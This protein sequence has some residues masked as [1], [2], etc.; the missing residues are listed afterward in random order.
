MQGSVALENLPG[1]GP[2]TQLQHIAVGRLFVDEVEPRQIEVSL[3][4]RR[5]SVVHALR[6]QIHPIGDIHLQLQKVDA[7]RE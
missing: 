6:I 1:K 5:L 4:Q 3:P 7:S 2:Q